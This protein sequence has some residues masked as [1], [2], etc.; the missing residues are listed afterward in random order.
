MATNVEIKPSW[1]DEVNSASPENLMLMLYDGAIRFVGQAKSAMVCGDGDQ[2][3]E[4]V[5]R[6]LAIVNYLSE[7]LD[8]DA[9]W[10]E[11]TRLDQLYMFMENELSAAQEDN[12]PES[13]DRVENMLIDL[14]NTWLEAVESVAH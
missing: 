4:A 8:H 2:R 3:H 5:G 14:H 7:T 12:K 10:D 9:G 6:A 13:L 1:Q 11:S